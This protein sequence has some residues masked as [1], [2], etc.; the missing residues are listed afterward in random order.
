MIE[1]NS[2]N[3]LLIN[4][5]FL[6]RIL[7]EALIFRAI[8]VLFQLVFHLVFQMAI[9]LACLGAVQLVRRSLLLHQPVIVPS[10]ATV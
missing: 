1:C 6:D 7:D 10:P 2:C 3:L 4:Q 9:N 8:Y 5:I